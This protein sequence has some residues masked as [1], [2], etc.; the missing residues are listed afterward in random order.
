MTR[1]IV[2][3]YEA[4]S[5][6]VGGLGTFHDS[7]F[8]RLAKKYEVKTFAMMINPALPVRESYKGI[9]IR[10]PSFEV[11][12]ATA[13]S[14][15]YDLFEHYGIQYDYLN[16][17]EID[18]P[19]Y[20][21]RKYSCIPSP[22]KM[23][24][25]DLFI[26]ND[27]MSIPRSAFYSWLHPSMPQEI[28]LHSF[29]PGRLGGVLHKN[30]NG[31]NDKIDE[32]DF[33]IQGSGFYTGKRI[34]RDLEFTLSYRIARRLVDSII[35]TVSKIHRKEY[36][37]G[38]NKHG[39]DYKSIEHKVYAIYH[40]VD[41]DFYE[42][43]KIEK[44]YFT[45]GIIGRCTPIKGFHI[46][47]GL[48][49]RL[50]KRIPNLRAHI[51][52][53]TRPDNPYYLQLEKEIEEKKLHKLINIDN[54]FYIGRGKVLLFNEWDVALVPSLYEPQ[55]QVDL[56]AMAC[57]VI[58]AVGMGGLREKV[59]D[60][61][62]GIWINP[63]N[64]VESADKIYQVYKGNYNGVDIEDLRKNARKTA[65]YLDWDRRAKVHEKIIEFILAG[66]IDKIKYI[67][68]ELTPDPRDF[69]G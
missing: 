62:N 53:S 2:D 58:P 38:I 43:V 4:G 24:K 48:V 63:Y 7:L 15:L 30:F 9:I 1:L 13:L 40:G 21:F 11:D 50:R 32:S 25:T 46:L 22:F 10:R 67:Q 66:D 51:V 8:S 20:F 55:G 59:I 28:I 23:A 35:L 14:F 44:E 65:E 34:I 27:W 61:L 18:F 60:G 64:I 31:T 54:T 42:P 39:G 16:E 29:E 56:E 47:P 68:D 45:I 52:T 6:T 17:Y 69:L 26:A 57:G 5:G 37:I 3:S 12:N 49:E 41:T 36:F 19:P 33:L